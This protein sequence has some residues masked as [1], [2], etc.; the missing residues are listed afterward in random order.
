[1]L[2]NVSADLIHGAPVSLA[3]AA[4]LAN[5]IE[6]AL[7]AWLLIRLA[8]S[9]VTLSTLREVAALILGAAVVSN[10]V[11]ALIG[12]TVLSYGWRMRFG[13]SLFA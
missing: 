5:S 2:G 4:G 9:P 3:L 1:M 8:G 10:A 6:V 7:A 12:A 11:T 13:T